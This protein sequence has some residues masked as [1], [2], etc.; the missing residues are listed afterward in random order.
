VPVP[1]ALGCGNHSWV[2]A[3]AVLDQA[4]AAAAI[5]GTVAVV[6]PIE[7]DWSTPTLSG[8]RE[9]SRPDHSGRALLE[10]SMLWHWTGGR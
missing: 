5:L 8:D 1:E 3:A 10:P 7:G 4:A 9:R 6:G 2:V